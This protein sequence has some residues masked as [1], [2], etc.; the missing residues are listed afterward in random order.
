MSLTRSAIHRFR[1][2]ISPP[3]THAFQSQRHRS[4]LSHP[5]PIPFHF[6]SSSYSTLKPD[7]VAG[8]RGDE[9]YPTGDFDF[10][11]VTGFN[12][13]LVKLK[14]LIAFPWERVQHGSIL[15]IILRGQVL[16]S[17]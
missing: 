1:Y 2:I 8:G 13:F 5:I 6:H 4:F 17:L 7:S 15:K 16:H 14:M 11:P 9:N 12:K 10:K 3:I